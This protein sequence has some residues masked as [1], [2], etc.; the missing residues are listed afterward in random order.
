MKTRRDFLK[1][2]GS[3]AGLAGLSSMGI[4]LSLF[5]DDGASLTGYKALVV[6]LQHGGNDSINMFVPSGD[7]VKKGHA[8]YASIR[9]SGLRVANNDLT[10]GLT[11]TNGKLSLSPTTN[12]YEKNGDIVQAYIKG[13]YKHSNIDGLATNGMMPEFAYLV[14]QGKVA[15]IA[16]AGNIIAP[17]SKADFENDHAI[18]P[19][20]L[21]SHNNQRKLLFNG[22]A[23]TLNRK[24]WAGLIADEWSAVN[25]NS[26][27]GLNL[28]INRAVHLLYG[29]NSE[30]LV[31]RSSGPTSYK[32]IDRPLYNNWLGFSESEHFKGLYAKLR[33]RTLTVQD[34]LVSDWNNNPLT[35]SATNVYG[36]ELFSL[37][38]VTTLGIASEGE[39]DD[40][41]LEQLNAVTRLAKIGKDL[42]LKR[43][44]FYVQH[45]AYDTH[46]NQALNHSSSLRE[47]SIG[48]NDLQSAL[49]EMGMEDEVTTFNLTDFGRSIG[50]N[51]DGTDHAW[52][53]HH[54]VL[55]GAVSGGLYGTLPDL[56]LGGEDDISRKGRLIPTTSMSQYLG[57]IVKWFGADEAMLNGLFPERVNFAKTDLGFMR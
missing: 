45:R 19:P 22:V 28:G 6:V 13:F 44:V 18:R 26:I 32:S 33:N 50:D 2:T 51:G 4:P 21:F 8:N 41:L 35:F 46:A 37:P 31:I 9:S 10:A 52:G 24:G 5:A 43:Q 48:L 15:M 7:D 36:G 57:T 39:V 54:F 29:E 16:N 11:E 12:P 30:P 27:Y 55:G 56:T 14:N 1:L 42:G 49:T 47:L 34:T 38:S 20:Y 3:Y 23:S 53:G 17:A 25:G 40:G